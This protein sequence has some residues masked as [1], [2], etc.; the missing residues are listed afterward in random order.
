MKT[1]IASLFLIFIFFTFTS[2]G[3][4][5]PEK[6]NTTFKKLYPNPGSKSY[7]LFDDFYEI[8]YHDAQGTGE[9]INVLI[10]VDGN[11]IG[12]KSNDSISKEVKTGLVE[13]LGLDCSSPAIKIVKTPEGGNLYYA[14]CYYAN[15]KGE[16]TTITLATAEGKVIKQGSNELTY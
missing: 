14:S 4:D 8:G 16:K 9:F 2:S 3:Q 12:T 5:L 6:V 10:D 15:E 7:S 13:K 1:K 11:F